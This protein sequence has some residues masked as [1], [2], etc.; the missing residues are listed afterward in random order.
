MFLTTFRNKIP[1]IHK[2]TYNDVFD[3]FRKISDH[4]PKIPEDTPK[5]LRGV[6]RRFRTFSEKVRRLPNFSEN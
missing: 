1:A 2:H 4:F 5:V 6:H 3:D